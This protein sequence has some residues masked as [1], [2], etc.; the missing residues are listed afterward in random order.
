[1]IDKDSIIL[2][3]DGEI[4]YNE[5]IIGTASYTTRTIQDVYIEKEF[6]GQGIGTLVVSEIVAELES[7]SYNFVRT[8][9]V[10]SSAMEEVLKKVGFEPETTQ[11]GIEWIYKY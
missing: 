4:L 10:V 11:E 3:D 2:T 6:R 1:M 9:T 5:Q 7:S 8:T